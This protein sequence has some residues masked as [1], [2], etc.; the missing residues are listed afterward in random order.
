MA[1][2]DYA[3]A[4]ARWILSPY[5]DWRAVTFTKLNDKDGGEKTFLSVALVNRKT[6]RKGERNVS[7]AG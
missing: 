2:T 7:W 3:S 4:N 1:A 5:N 6:S